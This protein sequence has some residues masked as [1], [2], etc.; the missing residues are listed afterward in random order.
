MLGVG[1]VGSVLGVVVIPMGPCPISKR[2]RFRAA[3]ILSRTLIVGGTVVLALMSD[4]I[5]LVTP[6]P[7]LLLFSFENGFGLLDLGVVTTVMKG[8]EVVVGGALVVAPV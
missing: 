4:E 8:D 5:V 2:S 7:P 6:R 3:T 1:V